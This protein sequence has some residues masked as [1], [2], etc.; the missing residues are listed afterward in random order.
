MVFRNCSWPISLHWFDWSWKQ[1]L[2]ETM[3][4]RPVHIWFPATFGPSKPG[5]WSFQ[6]S[7][8]ASMVPLRQLPAVTWK[9]AG[10]LMNHGL[11]QKCGWKSGKVFSSCHKQSPRDYILNGWRFRRPSSWTLLF[12]EH[13]TAVPTNEIWGILPQKMAIS[14]VKLILHMDFNRVFLQQFQGSS[15]NGTEIMAFGI[16]SMMINKAPY[17]GYRYGTL[18]RCYIHMLAIKLLPFLEC[19]QFPCH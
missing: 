19:Q 12:T 17:P 13:I 7:E 2:E 4:S 18:L 6:R 1:H 14:I 10:L 3:F 15:D 16:V 9:R 8:T 5:I 11:L